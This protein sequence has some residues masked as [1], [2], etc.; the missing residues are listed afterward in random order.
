MSFDLTDTELS[1]IDSQPMTPEVGREL[2]RWRDHRGRVWTID[3]VKDDHLIAIELFLIGRA[4]DFTLNPAYGP[5][6]QGWEDTYSTVR[7]EIDKRGLTLLNA[8]G[9]QR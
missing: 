7:D 9:G 3:T 8:E 6:N 1:I 5:G 2:W 4:P